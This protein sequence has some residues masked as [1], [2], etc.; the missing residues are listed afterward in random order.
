MNRKE[1]TRGIDLL[2]DRIE[3]IASSEGGEDVLD[4]YVRLCKISDS[5]GGNFA[6]V[7][8]TGLAVSETLNSEEIDDRYYY[9]GGYA[10]LFHIANTR[11]VE[12]LTSWRGSHD[13]DIVTDSS[14]V[15]NTIRANFE[16]T[17]ANSSSVCGKKNLSIMVDNS[18]IPV[19]V[20]L[21]NTQENNFEWLD[22]REKI[23]EK[24][25]IIDVLGV[26]VR[27]PK[28]KYLLRMK[29]GVSKKRD[30]L[31][32]NRD[33]SDICNLLGVLESY[34]GFSRK[35]SGIDDKLRY[36]SDNIVQNNEKRYR[37]LCDTLSLYEGGNLPHILSPPSNA[38]IH[39]IL[40]F[41]DVF[42]EEEEE[43]DSSIEEYN[44]N[45]FAGVNMNSP[46]RESYPESIIH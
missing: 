8:I 23:M 35:Y 28:I 12:A 20:D 43:R 42:I 5:K 46:E 9:I 32:R 10:T 11:G 33:K 41:P 45:Q 29:L 1:T 16:T 15:K 3:E 6:K 37:A 18:D 34:E 2:E 31:P 25:Q 13:L 19:D 26:R 39:Q 22:L 38:L 44:T 7:L 24:S 27:V 30:G 40:T 14:R 17:Q 36:I 21:Y 4:D